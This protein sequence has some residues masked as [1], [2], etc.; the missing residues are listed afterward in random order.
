MNVGAS[1]NDEDMCLIDSAITHIIL[2][3]NKIFSCLVIRDINVNIIYSITNIFEGFRR[4]I[5]LLSSS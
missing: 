4:V 3:S 1:I 5:I 2:K